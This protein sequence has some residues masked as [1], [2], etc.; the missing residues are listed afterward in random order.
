MTDNPRWVRA[1]AFDD[2][3]RCG[4]M[5]LVLEGVKIALFFHEGAAHAI[6][7]VCNHKGGPLA[8]GHRRDEFVTCPW[9]AWE[10]SVK[11]GCGPA[12]YDAES[13]AAYGEA[14]GDNER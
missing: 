14:A 10:Y 13:V 2:L 11:T 3:C 7:N 4:S 6:A 5:G 8:D 1:A 9:H 12:P